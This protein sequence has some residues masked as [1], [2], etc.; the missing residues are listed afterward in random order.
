MSRE[1]YANGNQKDFLDYLKEAIINAWE[2]I[3]IEVLKALAKSVPKD[4]ANVIEANSG[5]LRY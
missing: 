5:P 4:L 1:V 2:S 3:P